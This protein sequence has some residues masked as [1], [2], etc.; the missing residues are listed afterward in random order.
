VVVP[1]HNPSYSGGEFKTSL[2]KA[3]KTERERGQYV[4]WIKSDKK[5]SVS[6]EA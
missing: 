3:G 6:K 2:G 5:P 1:A 4:W